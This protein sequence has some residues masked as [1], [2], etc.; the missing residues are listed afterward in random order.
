M[1]SSSGTL[2]HSRTE[3]VSSP[4]AATGIAVRVSSSWSSVTSANAART[5]LGRRRHFFR[6]WA[7]VGAGHPTP[8][9]RPHDL[10]CF[11]KLRDRNLELRR[12]LPIAPLGTEQAYP[13]E[14]LVGTHETERIR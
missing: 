10:Q 13:G 2:R 3:C 14:P 7:V 1:N 4:Q 8:L 12:C 11:G 6:R 9:E 5:L